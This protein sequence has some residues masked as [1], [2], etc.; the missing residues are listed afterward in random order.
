MALIPDVD[1]KII[2]EDGMNLADTE[3]IIQ[4]T[5][6]RTTEEADAVWNVYDK[7]LET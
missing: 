2:K 7:D 3:Q 1:T 5:V 6:A 4:C